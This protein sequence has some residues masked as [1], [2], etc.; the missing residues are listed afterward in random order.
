MKRHKV[1]VAVFSKAGP[2][3]DRYFGDFSV[4]G[5]QFPGYKEQDLYGLEQDL[6]SD[7]QDLLR[8]KKDLLV[9]KQQLD[10]LIP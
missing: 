5:T 3:G 1:V 9:V 4:S 2:F 7:Q 6:H 10:L 8:N